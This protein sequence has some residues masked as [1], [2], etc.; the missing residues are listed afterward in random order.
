M[1]NAV[2]TDSQGRK[3]DFRNVVV[4]FTTNAGSEKAASLGFGSSQQNTFRDTA[5]KSLFKP[6]FRNRLDETVFFSPLPPAVILQVVH[7][8]VKEL[9]GQLATRKVT[10]DVSDGA[11]EWF[12]SKGFDPVFGARPMARLIQRELKN[13]LADEILFGA[14]KE[15]GVVRVGLKD[16]ALTFE[17]EREGAV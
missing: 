11:C 4:I 6:E 15:G 14:L 1:D 5:I 8:F 9:E 2:I 13:K 7:K 3:A 10:L 16:E 12:A 17:M